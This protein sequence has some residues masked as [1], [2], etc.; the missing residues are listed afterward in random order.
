VTTLTNT[1]YAWKLALKKVLQHWLTVRAADDLQKRF[2]IKKVLPAK[3]AGQK[4][5]VASEAA[6]FR[7]YFREA[8]SVN[9]LRAVG[10][11]HSEGKTLK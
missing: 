3:E 10:L 2:R 7:P 8:R 9:K 1:I 11:R 4:R 6:E 5:A